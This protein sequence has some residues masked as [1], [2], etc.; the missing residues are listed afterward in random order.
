MNR[1]LERW[2]KCSPAVIAEGSKAQM[3]FC[4]A[5]AKADIEALGKLVERVGRLNPDAEEIG[6]GMLRSLVEEARGLLK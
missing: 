5:D 4:I 1:S 6:A 2:Q 3:Q